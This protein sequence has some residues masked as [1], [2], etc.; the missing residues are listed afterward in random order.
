MKIRIKDNSIRIR[1][2]RS[3]IDK[4]GR[5]GNVSSST[6]FGSS[7][8]TYAIRVDE[9]VKELSAELVNNTLTMF[10]PL[11]VARQLMETDAIGFNNK[12]I[13]PNGNSLF[14]LIE[15]DF[16]CLDNEVLEDQSD[17]FDN[18]LATCTT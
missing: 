6:E 11:S 8:F 13:F 7:T 17:N 15:K 10:V 1:L 3:E 5:E 12:M 18:P 14:L 16:K 9:R 2:T 4:F